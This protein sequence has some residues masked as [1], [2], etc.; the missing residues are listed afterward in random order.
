[1]LVGMFKQIESFKY[2]GY[3]L[4]FEI[5]RVLLEMPKNWAITQGYPGLPRVIICDVF[6]G[7]FHLIIL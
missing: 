1:M 5:P 2:P 7:G 4:E 6:N 3:T